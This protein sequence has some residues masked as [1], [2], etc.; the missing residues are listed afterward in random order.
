M[1]NLH[2]VTFG[3]ICSDT[4]FIIFAARKLIKQNPVLSRRLEAFGFHIQ[5]G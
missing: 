2:P 1:S 5:I 3:H 4:L